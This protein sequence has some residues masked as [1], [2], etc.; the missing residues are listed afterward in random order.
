MDFKIFKN[1]P[2]LHYGISEKKDGFM[3]VKPMGSPEEDL[4]AGENGQRFY[5]KNGIDSGKV[6]TPYLVHGNRVAIVSKNNLRERLRADCFV[7]S[8]PGIVLTVTVAD[9]F[10]LYFYDPVRRAVGLAHA[11]WRGIVKN[12]VENA[13]QK[14]KEAFGSNPNDIL[15]AIGPGIQKCHFTVKSDVIDSF[16]DFPHFQK[17]ERFVTGGA[18]LYN[19]DL[20]SI[21]KEQAKSVGVNKIESLSECTYC[22]SDRY[23]SYRRDKSDPLETMLAYLS[24]G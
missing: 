18:D 12:I 17:Y 9:C 5:E 15:L 7:T 20:E 14:F 6:F 24:L 11:G 1:F 8:V 3:N 19:V 23:F 16:R 21:I 2:E 4:V 13:V 22:L 10:P